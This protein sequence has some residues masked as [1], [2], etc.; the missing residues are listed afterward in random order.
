MASTFTITAAQITA[1]V[2]TFTGTITSGVTPLISGTPIFI[3]GCTSAFFNGGFKITGGNLTTTFT[4]A[5]VHANFGPE[6]ESGATAIYDP[7]GVSVTPTSVIG[8]TVG[9][10]DFGR[11]LGPHLVVFGNGQGGQNVSG[12]GQIF[13]TGQQ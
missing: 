3:A 2:A 4:V 1:N 9:Y 12:V 8:N 11:F 13:P 6:A 5:L 7:E 10:S